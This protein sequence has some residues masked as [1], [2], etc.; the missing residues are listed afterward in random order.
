MPDETGTKLTYTVPSAEDLATSVRESLT[1]Y[2]ITDTRT[3]D[4]ANASNPE[5]PYLALHYLS[6]TRE[7]LFRAPHWWVDAIGLV[8]LQNDFLDILV[9]EPSL[10]IPIFD[11]SEVARFPPTFIEAAG[12]PT[13]VTPEMD[14]AAEDSFSVLLS[15]S[16]PLALRK[17]LPGTAPGKSQRTIMR[18]SQDLS[19]Q[20]IAASKSRGMT[21]TSIVQAA[22]AMAMATVAHAASVDGES[23]VLFFN[24]V[25]SRNRLP[26]P[27]DGAAGAATIY[28]TG[29]TCCIDLGSSPSNDDN[30]F[31]KFAK[32]LSAHY[33]KDIEPVFWYMVPYFQRMEQVF[34]APYETILYA[35]GTARSELSSLGIIDKYLSTRYEEPAATIDV[36]DWWLGIQ[37]MG[38]L[39]N[40]WLWTRDDTLHIGC[41]YNE[42]FYERA[43]VEG[44]F[45]LCLCLT[46]FQCSVLGNGLRWN[47]FACNNGQAG[48]L[49]TI[50]LSW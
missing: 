35:P 40:T 4:D 37:V 39:I 31:D 19:R 26:E 9:Q 6:S 30:N 18:F 17:V 48:M 27:W 44:F 16:A 7:F 25:S 46:G 14:K 28:H 49:E 1:V 50:R 11:G 41:S 45:I 22:M 13:D 15:E 10:E 42:S 23:R 33:Q 8:L 12:I 2:D 47:P 32:V 36:E 21:V 3:A 5:S 29:A 43:Y 38:R 20:I 34:M 24:P